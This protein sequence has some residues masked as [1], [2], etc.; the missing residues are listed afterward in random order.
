MNSK[1]EDWLVKK[2]LL[3]G[4]RNRLRREE[5]DSEGWSVGGG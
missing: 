2:G 5:V 4:N 1:R 3:G